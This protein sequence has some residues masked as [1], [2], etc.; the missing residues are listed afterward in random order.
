MDE[1]IKKVI[2]ITDDGQNSQNSITL[3]KALRELEIDAELF[4]TINKVSAKA[5]SISLEPVK[6]EIYKCKDLMIRC[7][8]GFPSDGL[9]FSIFNLKM[10]KNN[11][12]FIFGVNEHNHVG[13]GN[14]VSS[15]TSLLHLAKHFGYKAFSVSSEISL[16]KKYFKCFY[17]FALNI[18][19]ESENYFC[20]NINTPELEF[21]DCK[22]SNDLIDFFEV[23]ETIRGKYIILSY[24]QDY[25]KY[26]RGTDGYYQIKKLNY[27]VRLC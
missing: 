23:H 15:T 12:L 19:L 8:S 10:E 9:L 7:F 16:D 3:L 4:I 1:K 27:M 5:T 14:Y 25:I 18:C 26:K 6:Y 22:I 17:N 13:Y 24:N 21:F 11:T 20:F 2:I